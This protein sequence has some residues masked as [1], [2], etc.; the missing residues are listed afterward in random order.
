MSVAKEYLSQWN[1]GI[2]DHYELIPILLLVGAVCVIGI[3]LARSNKGRLWGMLGYCSCIGAIAV[4]LYGWTH[5]PSGFVIGLVSLCFILAPIA[6][7]ESW[8]KKKRK[9]D[10]QDKSDL[11]AS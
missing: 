11:P 3:V 5:A 9:R 8:R 2:M 4:V 10:N 6:H 1:G 7:W